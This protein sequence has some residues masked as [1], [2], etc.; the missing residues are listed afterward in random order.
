MWP[1]RFGPARRHLTSECAT[2]DDY[3]APLRLVQARPGP[4]SRP[5]GGPVDRHVGRPRSRG[6]LCRRRR[7][8]RHLTPCSRPGEQPPTRRIG[9][10]SRCALRRQSAQRCECTAASPTAHSSTSTSS[11]PASTGPTRSP[12][13]AWQHASAERMETERTM[14][15]RRQQQWLNGRID[16]V[17]GDVGHRRS[18]GH[19]QPICTSI[20]TTVVCQRRH[21]GRL[22]GRSA[23]PLR[24]TRHDG[25]PGRADR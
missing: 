24:S 25:Q 18:A 1:G 15:G 22:P 16:D 10:T 21:L 9:S 14:L 6:Q 12:G 20:G 11:T 3:R 19:C 23:T 17:D 8:W 13:T 7:R 5:S 2:L 4:A